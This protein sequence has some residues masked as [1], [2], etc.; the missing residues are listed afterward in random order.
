MLQITNVSSSFN[1]QNITCRAENEAG[2]G[3][4]VARLNVTCKGKGAGVSG[5]GG[6]F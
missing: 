3:E 2:M 4:A 1:L 6:P 5:L